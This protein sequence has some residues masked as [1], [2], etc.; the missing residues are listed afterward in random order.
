ML[1]FANDSHFERLPAYGHTND[2]LRRWP[3]SMAKSLSKRPHTAKV[4]DRAPRS[5]CLQLAFPFLSTDQLQETLLDTLID[6]FLSIAQTY[7][8]FL[9]LCP[10]RLFS[11]HLSSS[12][13]I[14]KLHHTFLGNPP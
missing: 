9:P 6:L 7:C 2:C 3:I 10:C 13:S 8:G 5:S 1:L 11:L 14:E 4:F 12:D